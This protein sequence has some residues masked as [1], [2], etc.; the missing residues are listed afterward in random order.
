LEVG[1]MEK[2]HRAGRDDSWAK[3]VGRSLRRDA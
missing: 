3:E 1:G 2:A